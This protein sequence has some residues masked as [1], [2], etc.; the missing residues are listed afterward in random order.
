MSLGDAVLTFDEIVSQCFLF[1]NAG[2]QTTST[3]LIF[4]I[5]E[6]TQRLDLQDK[7]RKEIHKVLAKH[8]DKITYDSLNEMNYMEQVIK[9]MFICI[10]LPSDSYVVDVFSE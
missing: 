7:V 10:C 8:D 4:S 9:G 1:F 3:T 2:F 5:F 6:L